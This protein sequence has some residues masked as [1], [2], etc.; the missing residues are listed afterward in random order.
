MKNLLFNKKLRVLAFFLLC[1]FSSVAYGQQP[2]Q[3]CHITITSDFESQCLMPLVKYDVYNEEPEAIIACQENTVTYTASCNTGGVAVVQWNWN[4]VGASTWMDNGNGSITVTWGAGPTGQ[5]SV[6]ITT[7][8]DYSCS[9]TQ[10]VKLIEKPDILA[11]TIPNY[12]ETPNHDK[13]ITVCKGGTVEFTDLSN[14]TNSDIIGYYWECDNPTIT[15]SLPNFRL[16]NVMDG[17]EVVHRVYNNCGCYDEEVFT[18]KVA[19]GDI[20]EL[21]CYG[22]VCQN[23]VVTYTALNPTCSQYSW[24]VEGGS[25]IGS[26]DQ[27][28]VTVQWD[29][30]QNGYGV[31]GLDGMLCGENSCPS[32]MSKKIPVIQDTLDI[33]GQDVV[34][35]GEA[36]RYSIPL[37]GSTEYHWSIQPTIGVDT[38]DVNGANQ[39]TIVFNQPGDYKIKVSY[40]C[41][42]LECGRFTSKTLL[43]RVKPKLEIEGEER[44]CVTNACDLKTDPNVSAKWSV[45]DIDNNDHLIHTAYNLSTFAYNF[46]QAGKYRVTAEHPDY[47]RP[48]VFVITVVDAPPAP[49]AADF[50]L[51]NPQEACP[52]SSILLKANPTNPDY[53]IVWEPTC[54]DATPGMVSGNRVTINYQ[55]TV[56]NINAYNYDRV[57]GCLSENPYVHTVSEFQLAGH[58]LPTSITVCPGAELP[59][60]VQNQNGVTYEW[61]LDGSHQ[62]CASVQ[63][64]NTSNAVTL[65]VNKLSSYPVTFNFTLKRTYCSGMVDYHTI[66]IT[67]TDDPDVEL[68][69]NHSDPVCQYS[70]VV[71]S[72]SGCNGNSYEWTIENIEYQGNPISHIFRHSGSVNVTMKCNPYYSCPNHDYYA[73]KTVTVHVNAAP[74]AS[75]I[76]FSGSQVYVIPPLSPSNYDFEWGHTSTN[77]NAVSTD[78]T[79]DLYTCTVT[80]RTTGC[81]KTVMAYKPCPNALTVTATPFDYC[82]KQVFLTATGATGPVNWII[83]GGEYSVV[84]TSGTFGENTTILIETAGT[85]TA[86]A[87]VAG[88][89]CQSGTCYFTADF[90]HDFTFEKACDKIII[91]NNSSYINGNEMV[92]LNY[93]NHP[94]VS[95]RADQEIIQVPVGSGTYTFYFISFNGNSIPPCQLETISIANTSHLP[96]T[97]TL[98]FSTPQYQACENSPIQLT[99]S[100]PSPH[101]ISEINWNFADGSSFSNH[102]PIHHTFAENYPSYYPV[103]VQVKDENACTL[104]GTVQVRSHNNDLKPE[105]LIPDGVQVCEGTPRKLSYS[106]NG[107]SVVAPTGSVTYTWDFAPATYNPINYKYVST[108]GDYGVTVTN[109]NYCKV[110]KIKNVP[111]SNSPYALIV[112]ASS[113]YC[114][115][116]TI[117]FYGS[118]DPN[119]SNYTFYW[120]ITD[121][122]TGTVNTYSDAD[123]SYT[124]SHAGTYTVSLTITNNEGCSD[125]AIETITVNPTPTAPTLYYSGNKCLD[126]GA[127]ELAGTTPTTP[128]SVI[129][130]SNGYTGPNAKYFTAGEA[131]AWYYDINTGCKS[132]EARIHIEPQPDFDALLTGCYEKCKDYFATKPQPTLPV[133]GLSSGIEYIKWDWNR[134]IVNNVGNGLVYSP[135]YFLSLLLPTF[136]DYNLELRYNGGICGPVISPTL[137]IKPTDT[138]DCKDLDID[139]KYKMYVKNCKIYYDVKVRVCNN[140]SNDAC[141]ED[142]QYLFDNQYIHVVYAN[143]TNHTVTPGNCEFI[144]MLIEVAQFKPS[145]TISFRIYDKCNKCATD[146]SIN[147]MPEKFECEMP[148][149]VDEININHGLSSEVAGYFKFVANVNPAEN[150]L[151][152]WTEPPMVIDYFYDGI[153][154]VYGMN[155]I[156]MSLLSQL[157][158]EDG[159]ICFYALTCFKDNLC[160]RKFCMPAKK[161]YEMFVNEGV[162][163]NSAKNKSVQSESSVIDEQSIADPRLMPN[164]TTGEVNVI[165]TAD[166]V[167]EVMVMDLNGRKMAAFDNTTNFNISNLSSGIYIVRVKTKHDYA[168]KVTYLKLV[169]K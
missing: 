26:Q 109:S 120:E 48:A 136:G 130:W 92:V 5:I 110:K 1:L 49:V 66:E 141:L 96:V 62:Y 45:Y 11:G 162:I 86:M 59:F 24:Y 164:P 90:V 79:V 56:C 160:L 23:A 123:I 87:R 39:R 75:G 88:N 73:T 116:E 158:A 155:M 53:T 61:E 98:P 17:C 32:L 108:T 104:T 18:I 64:D 128:A 76:A 60:S 70:T 147:L 122:S 83:T 118:P 15:S 146:F 36:V 84:S 127:V 16:E 10:N 47:C 157:V 29:H 35:V 126:Q 159:D 137:T 169:K 91:K 22:T 46:P 112:T 89:P 125:N 65:L 72:G 106:V 99:A 103:T 33:N 119:T 44:I 34:C 31:I 7:A 105:H 107:T 95:F 156:D 71:L 28:K 67:V 27:P 6:E 166:E 3:A 163:H 142:V 19:K 134:D 77:S 100:I 161:L 13:I 54:D 12:V 51:T 55:N 165:G 80:N 78:P 43:V 94:P 124:P 140:S 102:N 93:G 101:I 4:V 151:D 132:N 113:I 138:C 114:Q 74:P 135:G 69:I 150:V 121:V 168:E 148:M 167:V 14:T 97:I 40:E 154:K 117:K 145:S 42:F 30:P 131:Q 21:G 20:L 52:N 115:G 143:Y 139:Y 57:L 129:N 81:S 144:N 38:F 82:S 8:N 152:F 58:N 85:Y 41:E 50:A 111:F 63:G 37:F 2:P 9:T 149:N 68:S 25:I 153:D 133:W